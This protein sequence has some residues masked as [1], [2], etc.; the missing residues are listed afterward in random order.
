MG[1]VWIIE[2]ISNGHIKADGLLLSI[3]GVGEVT[4][5]VKHLVHLFTWASADSADSFK[6]K[7]T[8]LQP[9]SILRCRSKIFSIYHIF[10]LLWFLTPCIVYVSIFENLV[11]ILMCLHVKG[12][13]EHWVNKS[14][15]VTLRAQEFSKPRPNSRAN[16]SC[17]F[18]PLCI[19]SW[20]DTHSIVST[21]TRKSFLLIIVIK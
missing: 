1:A 17:I 10:N 7:D 21:K 2:H 16:S 12:A 8:C 19:N 11:T 6:I 4:D 14:T 5:L 3:V 9:L 13:E 15:L 18:R 20:K